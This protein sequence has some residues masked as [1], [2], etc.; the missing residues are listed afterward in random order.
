MGLTAFYTDMSPSALEQRKPHNISVLQETVRCG[1]SMWDTADV[2]GSSEDLIGEVFRTGAVKREQVF[3]ATKFAIQVNADGTR[4]I[5]GD[6]EYVASSIKR[7]L[8]RLGVPVIDLWYAHRKDPS[9]EIEETVGA[10][11]LAVRDGHVRFLGL[12]ECSVE[13][14]IRGHKEHPISALQVELSPFTTSILDNGLLQAA[15]ERGVKI[16]AYSP[17]GRGMLCGKIRS[18]DDLIPGDWRRSN[19]RWMG[20]CFKANLELSDLIGEIAARKGCTPGQLS[21]AWCLSLGDDIIPIPGTTN[22]DRVR[23][24]CMAANIRLT[25]DERAGINDLVKK[26]GVAGA[27]YPDEAMKTLFQ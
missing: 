26:V 2:Y 16:V 8:S 21:L 1:A 24:N 7:S 12:S 13:S 17:L 23:E 27:R 19:P 25:A 5:R 15:R 11:K 9:V 6:T 20:D 10:M 22:L 14:L 18:P 3:L 4:R